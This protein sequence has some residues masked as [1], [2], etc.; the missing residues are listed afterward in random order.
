MS[1]AELVVGR[2]YV[3]RGLSDDTRYKKARPPAI[4]RLI[5][6]L[7]GGELLV[8]LHLGGGGL[9][10]RRWTPK[11]RRCRLDNVDREATAREQVIGMPTGL[12]AAV[13]S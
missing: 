1:A 5:S 12:G 6:F 13:A 8:K 10:G 11:P 2:A 4:A 3:L 9:L 7:P